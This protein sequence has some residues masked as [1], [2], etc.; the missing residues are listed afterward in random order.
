MTH[1]SRHNLCRITP[2]HSNVMLREAKHLLFQRRIADSSAAPQN[3][4]LTITG[5]LF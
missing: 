4:S 1:S 5:E 3:D 2:N